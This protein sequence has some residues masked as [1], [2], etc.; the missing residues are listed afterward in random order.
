MNIGY[1]CITRGPAAGRYRT[2]RKQNATPEHLTTLIKHNLTVLENM[3]EYNHHQKIRLF[4]MSS[5]MIPFGSDFQTNTLDWSTLFKSEFERIGK[6]IDAY[7]M[8]VSM[9]PGQYTVLN[10]PDSGVVERAVDDLV[11]HT[12]FMENLNLDATH[13]IIL[14][15]GGV[16]GD[17]ETAIDRFVNTYEK[18]DDLIK[19]RLI[20]ENDDRSYNIEEVIEISKLTGAPVVYD[21]LHHKINHSGS[22]GNDYDWV[23]KAAETW[24]KNDGRPKVHYSEQQIGGRVGSHS[25]SVSIDAFL[26]FYNAVS[27]LDIDIMLEVKDKN[28]SARKCLL[29]TSTKLDI[30]ELE[31]EWARYKYSVL[32]R[33]PAIYNEIR[34]L[35]KD[36]ED[37]P[38]VTFYRLIE[39]ALNTELKTGPSINAL[40]HVWGYVKNQVTDKEKEKFQ[41]MKL[42]SESELSKLVKAKAYVL[43]LAEKY[44]AAYLLQSLYFYL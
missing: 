1:A 29:A 31:L 43:K 19:K 33:S 23:K 5:D 20:I 8:R 15:I 36:K 14:H 11:Y 34:E 17:K 28:L 38:V 4:R 24:R 32:E 10:S 6:K 18:L 42:A 21:N 30:K 12:Q 13:K 25:Q 26:E 35:L 7:Q 39:N 2:C 22:Y 9:H 27:P 41:L 40:E 37:Y 16:Y 3:I 44:D